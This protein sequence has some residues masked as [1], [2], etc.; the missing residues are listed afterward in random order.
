MTYF[1]YGEV[2]VDHLRR[3]DSRLGREIDRIGM[4][5]AEM[6]PDVFTALVSSVVGQQI[7]GK[8]AA[9]V[10]NRLSERFGEITP[11]RLDEAPLEEIRSCGM[12]SRKAQYV[13]GIAK[14]CLD[15]E[16]DLDRLK[17]LP[18][19]EV[20]K[21]LSSLRGIGV[22]TAEMM[23]IFC[24]GRKDVVSWGDLAIRRGMARLYGLEKLERQDFLRLRER[25]SPF[26]SVASLYLW[27]IAH[28]PSEV[29]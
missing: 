4:L 24:L 25:Y 13:K 16:L 20:V 1:E 12:S 18:D 15:G 2:E 27:E 14:A 11:R 17:D 10:W 9:T 19:E 22:W 8:A 21:A 6:F 26:G 5:R 28:E 7:S 23:L 29:G 3:R